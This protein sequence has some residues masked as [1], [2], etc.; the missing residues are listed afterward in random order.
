MFWKS[1]VLVMTSQCSD[2]F[3]LSSSFCL[4]RKLSLPHCIGSYTSALQPVT[5]VMLPWPLFL[6]AMHSVSE[7]IHGLLG[8]QIL[9]RVSTAATWTVLYIR[10]VMPSKS[11]V[12]ASS[13]S[14]LYSLVQKGDLVGHSLSASKRPV[15]EQNTI[16]S[17]TLKDI[18]WISNVFTRQGYITPLHC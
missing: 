6:F 11:S 4:F 17:S 9:G 12:W 14:I 1:A 13:C 5:V 2:N 18:W 8:L 7:D 16:C 15:Q 3:Y 10:L